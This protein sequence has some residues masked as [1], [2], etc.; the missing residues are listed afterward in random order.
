MSYIRLVGR[1]DRLGA[2]LTTMI[3]QIIFAHKN[4]LA[5][6]FEDSFIFGDDLWTPLYPLIDQSLL[7]SCFVQSLF[8]YL[9]K[10]N[11]Q[12]GTLTFTNRVELPGTVTDFCALI[13]AT[14][15]TIKTDLFSYF[16][17]EIFP[18]LREFL[19]KRSAKYNLP[20]DLEDRVL[21][22]L[23]TDDTWWAPDYDGRVCSSYFA[24][25]LNNEEIVTEA[26]IQE[27]RQLYGFQYNFQAG[28][29]FQ[30]IEALLENY[31]LPREKINIITSPQNQLSLPYP[32]L[33]SPDPSYDLLLLCRAK[34]VILSRSTFALSSL[35]F[36]SAD[37]FY[38][39][40]WGQA[41]AFGLN[42]KYDNNKNINYFF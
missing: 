30:R 21:I 20:A 7:N 1:P 16:R 27:S 4:G 6:S 35:F 11:A 19:I 22:H 17:K 41:T 29:D 38:V 25:K 28:I 31:K 2:N 37:S 40:Q 18:E 39:P 24:S 23:R 32:I 10:Y 42:T 3:A 34:N 36:G 8:D 26:S 12:L 14:V 9:I 33:A 13:S 5:V 15:L